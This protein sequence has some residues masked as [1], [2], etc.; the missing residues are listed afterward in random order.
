ELV[1]VNNVQRCGGNVMALLI[2]GGNESGFRA[3]RREWLAQS[4]APHARGFSIRRNAQH[5][6]VVNA[7]S[8]TLLPAL[9][10]EECAIGCDAQTRGEL[11]R[12][13]GLRE[14][15]GEQFVRV[16]L[17]ITVRIAQSPNAVAIE[18]E[19]V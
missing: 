19:Q 14:S 1:I 17:T 18:N 9:G 16:A 12:L 11:A 15:V 10:D 7:G 5:G 3:H 6:A 4:P 2:A 13:G 8:R